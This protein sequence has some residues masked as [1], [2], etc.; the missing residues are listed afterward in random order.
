M[1]KSIYC[2]ETNIKN[3]ILGLTQELYTMNVEHLVAPENQNV[4]NNN[5]NNNDGLMSKEPRN[6]LKVCLVTKTGT[7]IATK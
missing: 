2:I 4:L 6:Q 1:M 7:I 5:N 3:T